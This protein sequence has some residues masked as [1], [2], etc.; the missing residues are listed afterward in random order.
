MNNKM[1]RNI[2]FGKIGMNL[3]NLN[4]NPPKGGD[5]GGGGSGEGKGGEGG[6][7]GRIEKGGRGIY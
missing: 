4:L 1:K 7:F 2:G 5:E 6:V 3:G